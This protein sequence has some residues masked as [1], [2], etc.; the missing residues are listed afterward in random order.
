MRV[1]ELAPTL[2]AVT[3]PV[4]AAVALSAVLLLASCGGGTASPEP[5][6]STASPSS[7]PAAPSS[8]P[9]AAAAPGVVAPSECDDVD[10]SP[11]AAVPGDV[12]AACVVAFSTAAGTGHEHL[13][14][15]SDSAEV[16]FVYGERPEMAGTM[17]TS[18]GPRQFVLT[19]DEAWVTF[20]GVW[21]RGDLTSSD[22][23]ALLAA[24]VGEAYR[25]A[26]DPSMTAAMIGS[27]GSVGW[28]VQ[29]D[30]DVLT[31]EDGTGLHAW[32]LEA[33]EPF[34]ALGAR[35]V[36]MVVWLGSDHT[37]AGNQATVDV[38]GIQTTT[39]QRYSRWGLPVTIE[40][41]RP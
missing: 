20:D 6:A 24:T 9:P 34:D 22:P 5:G 39:V 37:V 25:A 2:G 21:V 10:L 36:E 38:G 11:G 16:D 28:E 8:A 27:V 17:T 32:R 35:V 1:P 19:Q 13:E 12:L 15:G 41:P 33:T 31:Q 7:P 23:Q 3:R 4:R 18:E 29:P 26:A 40:P 14:S 30:Q